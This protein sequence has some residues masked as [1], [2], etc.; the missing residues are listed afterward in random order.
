[1]LM[2]ANRFGVSLSTINPNTPPRPYRYINVS[3]HSGIL[4]VI[5]YFEVYPLMGVKYLDYFNWLRLILL[6]KVYIL[7]HKGN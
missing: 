2:I 5:E 6:I 7:L 1:M 4:A 3:A